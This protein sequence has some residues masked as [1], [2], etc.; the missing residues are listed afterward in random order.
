M[1]LKTI[2]ILENK[3]E[4]KYFWTIDFGSWITIYICPEPWVA[5][6]KNTRLGGL[7]SQYS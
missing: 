2:Q 1:A 4:V 6:M 3:S 7:L 5:E